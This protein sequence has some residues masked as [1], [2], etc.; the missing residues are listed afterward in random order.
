MSRFNRIYSSTLFSLTALI[1]SAGPSILDI[2]HHN[3]T[4]TI[5][6]PQAFE[7]AARELEESFFLKKYTEPSADS[8][9]HHIGTPEEYQ[10][11][12]AKLPAEIEMPYNSAVGNF[13]D[14]YLDRRRTLLSNMLALHNYYGPI[15]I[16]ELSKEGLPLELQYLPVIESAINPNAVSRVGATGLWQFMS[17]T[18]SGMGLEINSLVDERRDPRK[19]SEAAAKYLK[20]LYNIYD[21]WSLAIAA[22]N[23]GPGNVNKALR[24]AGGGKLD[25]WEIYNYLPKETRGYVPMFIAANY[26]MNYHDKYGIN[27]AVV[28]HRLVT[29]TVQVNDRLHFQ[30]IADVLQVPIDD[31]RMLN[32]QFRKDIIP[33]NSRPY[34]LVLP[35]QQALSYIVSEDAIINY[36]ADKYRPRTYVE[37]GERA[38]RNDNLTQLADSQSVNATQNV[39]LNTAVSDRME[40]LSHTV[41]RGESLRDIAKHYGVSSTDIK[42]WN[43]LRRGKVKEG[44]VIKIQVYKREVAEASTSPAA[45]STVTTRKNETARPASNVSA[46]NDYRNS[47]KTTAANTS[48]A[49]KPKTTTYKVKSGDTLEKIARRN[50]TTVEAIQKANGMSKGTTR[51]GIGKDLKIPAPSKS[52]SSKSSSKSSKSS[53]SKKKSGKKRR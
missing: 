4:D 16:E 49:K 14:M 32:P 45:E 15:F 20:Q 7:L 33:G 43:N 23:C 27:P 11:W 41:G 18:G 1:A 10:E 25:F 37:P 26:V 53:K 36:D 44:D 8:K 6:T 50:G 35:S 34:S 21:D 12:L 2:R 40:E 46:S 30:Q 48:K 29:D 13:I 47:R 24:K 19:S 51:I 9:N 38:G 28:K 22:Y 17:S 3:Y 52:S 5:A 42:R 39:A 31:I